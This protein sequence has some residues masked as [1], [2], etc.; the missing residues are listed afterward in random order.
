M[1]NRETQAPIVLGVTCTFWSLAVIIVVLRVFARTRVLKALGPDD[2]WMLAAIH[3]SLIPRLLQKQISLSYCIGCMHGLGKHMK[4]V[5]EYDMAIFLKL[6]YIVP[7]QY[8]FALGF[9]KM[10]VV[11]FYLRVFP[12]KIFRHICYV[13][14]GIVAAATLSIAFAQAFACRPISD[15]WKGAPTGY[16]VNREALQ[17]AG[18][19][20]NLATD[21]IVLMLPLKY[22]YA[23]ALDK[24]RRYGIIAL[25]SLGSITCIASAY[26]LSTI[27]GFYAGGDQTWDASGLCIWSGIEINLSIITASIPAIKTLIS[28]CMKKSSKIGSSRSYGAYVTSSSSKRPLGRE[29]D[30]W[31]LF[32]RVDAV[33]V[34]RDIH[35]QTEMKV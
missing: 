18:S 24:A 35:V 15:A 1:T 19:V 34:K 8:P 16:C 27:P 14:M 21:L 10:S 29:E 5:G 2:W 13:V 28:N 12:Q 32:E 30:G 6:S 33:H 23:M 25:F 7:V 22:L 17:I 9:V 3:V 31:E 11:S 4:T 20:I 26:R